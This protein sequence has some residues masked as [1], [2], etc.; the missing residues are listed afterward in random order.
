[1]VAANHNFIV[2]KGADVVWTL[3]GSDDTGT[4]ID[5][6]THTVAMDVRANPDSS[7]ELFTLTQGNG[8]VSTV[9]GSIVFTL[10]SSDTA[11]L[12]FDRGVFD[13]KDTDGSGK[14]NFLL[15]GNFIVKKTV[16]R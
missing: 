3:A 11:A 10:V 14:S 4:P 9:T 16:T 5:F 8:R 7:S 13:I 1:M 15:S 6:S 12:T 2:E